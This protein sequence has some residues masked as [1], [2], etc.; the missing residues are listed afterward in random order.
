[1][2]ADSAASIYRDRVYVFWEDG[3]VEPNALPGQPNRPGPGRILFA[4]SKDKGNSWIE[5]VIL[6]EQSDHAEI[7]YGAYMPA[8][9]VN[10]DGLV[11][12]TWYDRR[13]QPTAPGSTAPFHAPS[14]N[15]RIRVSLDGGETWQP[16]VQVNETPIQSSV[17]DLRDT[18][19][20]AADAAGTFHP[21]WIDDRTGTR[22]LWTAA[23]QVEKR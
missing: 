18:A 10:K 15:V 11:A 7:A 23:V 9:A 22:Q 17:W 4:F 1:M 12:V 19:G 2:A 20:L 13:G 6:S 5:P 14:C 16:S 21:V 3:Q 8:V